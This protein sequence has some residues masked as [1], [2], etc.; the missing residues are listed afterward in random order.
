[1]QRIFYWLVVSA[2]LLSTCLYTPPTT[3]P[4]CTPGNIFQTTTEDQK[5][6]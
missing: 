5:G 4:A 6:R 3:A 2:I 1:M